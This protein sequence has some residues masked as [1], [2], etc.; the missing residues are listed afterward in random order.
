MILSS[1]Y[2]YENPGLTLS[3]ILFPSQKQAALIGFSRL[4]L[5]VHYPTDVLAG[6][7]LG[8]LLGWVGCTLVSLAGNHRITLK[9][10]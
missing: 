3:A 8:T 6:V 4:Y 7:V 5:Y 1:V 9:R 2:L 10:G